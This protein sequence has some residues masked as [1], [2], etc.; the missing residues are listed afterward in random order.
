MLSLSID[1]SS[2]SSYHAGGCECYAFPQMIVVW[3]PIMLVVV[4]VEPLKDDSSLSSYHVGE[5]ECW[6][7]LI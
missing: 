2:L 5:C 7:F 6:A 3:V 1:G 4:S